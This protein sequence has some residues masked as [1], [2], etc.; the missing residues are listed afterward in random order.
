MEKL[1]DGEVGEKLQ[2][3]VILMVVMLSVFLAVN[4][5][6]EVMHWR[7][8]GDGVPA[9]N[10]ITIL[11]HGEMFVAPDIATFTFTIIS[12]KATVADAQ[13]DVTQKVNAITAYLSGAEVAEKD[14]KTIDY[15]VSPQ[16]EYLQ[17]QCPTSSSPSSVGSVATVYCPPGKQVLKGFQARQTT[18]VKVRNIAKVG[19][20][21]DGVGSVGVTEMSGL[22]FTFD[23]PDA[24]DDKVR[25]KAIVDAKAKA[26]IL[27][28]SLGVSLVRI[29]SFTENS[30]LDSPRQMYG[31][32]IN[33]EK[34]QVPQIFVGQN[35]ITND[36][37][38]TYEIR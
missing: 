11:G 20:I 22:D 26:K 30:G 32:L 8:I 19:D 29:V 36:V 37:S 5:I 17:A 14:I 15:L 31:M 23:D 12:K 24:M 25:D 38:I 6:G 7:Y 4:A 9:T 27:A 33:E 13:A 3:L 34:V 18:M 35:K 1:F 21:L 16:Y 10:I 28:K 2:R